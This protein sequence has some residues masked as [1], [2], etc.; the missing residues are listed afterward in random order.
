MTIPPE[1]R[2]TDLDN[3]LI[4]QPITEAEV[5]SA[6]T[7]LKRKAAVPDGLNNDFYKDTV[8]LMVPALF[9]NW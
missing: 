5:L 1:Q 3:D 7:G 2:I 4:L 6:I 9:H 8:A